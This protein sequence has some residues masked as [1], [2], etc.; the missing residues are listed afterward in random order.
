MNIEIPGVFDRTPRD[1]SVLLLGFLR[2]LTYQ[3]SDLYYT[4]AAGILK[5]MI[6]NKGFVAMVISGEIVCN[7][8]AIGNDLF[9][10]NYIPLFHKAT[11]RLSRSFSKTPDQMLRW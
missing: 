2:E 5:H 8:F 11:P 1:S 9:Q 4:H 6:S 3:L 7:P 10:N